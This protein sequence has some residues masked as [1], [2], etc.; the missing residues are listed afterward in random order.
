MMIRT[1]LNIHVNVLSKIC[2]TAER[3]D[4]SMTK[5]IVLLLMRI[6]NDMDSFPHRFKTVSYQEDDVKENW[7]CF[8]IKFRE[9]HNEYFIDLRK[10]CKF[11]VS[12]LLAIAVKRYLDKLI[13]DMGGKSGDNYVYYTNYVLHGEEI[14]GVNS[15]TFYW[16]FPEEHLKTYLPE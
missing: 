8:H 3:L 16:G 12:F 14:E 4:T 6:M 1:T 5:V 9:D 2:E 11:S 10:L 13:E 7:H 15:F